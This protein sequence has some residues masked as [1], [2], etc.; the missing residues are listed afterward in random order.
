MAYTLISAKGGNIGSSISE[1][2]KLSVAREILNHP[3]AHKI[4]LPVDSIAAQNL[5]YGSER[6]TFPSDDIPDGWRGLDLG[7][8]SRDQFSSEIK[9]A[10]TVLWNGP[11]GLY[12]RESFAPGTRVVGLAMVYVTGR[13]G[14]VVVGGGDTMAA[15]NKFNMTAPMT[16][17]STG[18][19]SLLE[20]MEN[21]PLPGFE[22]LSERK[23]NGFSE[24][25]V[26]GA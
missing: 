22:A 17:V 3:D 6:K 23:L 5:E 18:G 21:K 24:N 13:G 14:V 16:H 8:E 9:K 25:G 11:M 26:K 10:A 4:V 7:R 20:F 2:E 19:G 1:P 12:E 15:L